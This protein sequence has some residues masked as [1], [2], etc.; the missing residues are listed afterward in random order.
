MNES[1]PIPSDL[2]FDESG[3]S[4]LYHRVRAEYSRTQWAGVRAIL[5]A[6]VDDDLIGLA[7]TLAERP[8]DKG[9][10]WLTVYAWSAALEK[11][12]RNAPDLLPWRLETKPRGEHRFFGDV[13]EW[14]RQEWPLAT[15]EM[16]VHSIEE[17]DSSTKRAIVHMC[18]WWASTNKGTHKSGPVCAAMILLLADSDPDVRQEAGW[19][20]TTFKCPAAESALA[21]AVRRES[22]PVRAAA[23]YALG[24]T[25][26]TRT[27]P[28][29]IAGT[30]DPHPWVRLSALFVL[31]VSD[32]VQAMSIARELSS[33]ED[34]IVAS[35][36]AAMIQRIQRN[37]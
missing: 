21:A 13:G 25:A 34:P 33:D 20:L 18:G 30:R 19:A 35:E 24:T 8:N 6:A 28:E 3:P 29:L 7:L 36:S 11:L 26:R 4:Q 10:V 5:E 23:L 31:E 1:L 17:V 27:P 37:R 22:G 16:L 14:I 32:P 9:A 12:K 15:L 2:A